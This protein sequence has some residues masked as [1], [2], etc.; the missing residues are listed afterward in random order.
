[1]SGSQKKGGGES[2]FDLEQ[3]FIMRLPPVGVKLKPKFRI[4]QSE[5]HYKF[6]YL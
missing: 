5:L 1:M 4:I 2:V 3:Q 6:G